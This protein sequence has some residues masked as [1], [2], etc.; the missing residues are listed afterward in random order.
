MKN[1]G[2]KNLNEYIKWLKSELEEA[3]AKKDKEL[4]QIAIK[5]TEEDN[6]IRQNFDS[7]TVKDI[8]KFRCSEKLKQKL[9]QKHLD[10]MTRREEQYESRW[11]GQKNYMFLKTIQD[12]KDLMNSSDTALYEIPVSKKPF[13]NKCA[14]ISDSEMKDIK[15][16]NANKTLVEAFA[17]Y[18]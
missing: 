8:D 5:K 4:K 16:R 10:A 18:F 9:L 13:D 3:R 17:T 12:I 15:E 7:Y 6:L 2:K 11:A 1:P 14:L